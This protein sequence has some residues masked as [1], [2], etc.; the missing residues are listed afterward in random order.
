MFVF[1][2]VHAPAS[3]GSP[4]PA[5]YDGSMCLE[6]SFRCGDVEIRYPFYLANATQA[7]ADYSGNYSADTPIFEISC[8]G[9]GPSVSPVIRLSGESYTVVCASLSAPNRAASLELVVKMGPDLSEIIW[10]RQEN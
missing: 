9:E 8:Q 6:S 7:T 5:T 10:A 1:L 2:A 4:L 3:H